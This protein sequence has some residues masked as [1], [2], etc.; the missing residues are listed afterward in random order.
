MGKK[1]KDSFQELRV[2]AGS[3]RWVCDDSI[4]GFKYTSE[5]EPLDSIVGQPR[6]IEAIKLGSQIDS[7]GYNIFVTG[8]SGTGRMTAVKRLLEKIADQCPITYDYAYVNNFKEHDK[9]NLI[10]LPRSRGKDFKKA[11]RESLDLIQQR[12]PKIFEDEEYQKRRSEIVEKF[13]QKE[14][15]II[16]EFDKRIEK[17][18]FVRG[19]LESENGQVTPEVF[20]VINEKPTRIEDLDDLVED[21]V[22]SQEKANELKKKYKGFHQEV[23]RLS[24]EGMH[25]MK[26]YR[27]EM[28]T[29]DRET[30]RMFVTSVYEE[31]A[32][33]F[34]TEKIKCFIKELIDYTLDNLAELS[35]ALDPNNKEQEKHL[36]K[37][38]VN[39]ILDNTDTELP[40][41]II[42]RYPNYSNLFGSFER[43]YDEKGNWRTDFTEIRAGSILRADKGFLI[44]NA[45]DMFSE[46]GVW[47]NLKR[48]L[49]YGKLDIQAQSNNGIAAYLKPEPID[50]DVKVIIIGGGSLYRF[51]YDNEKGFKKIFKVN[52]QFDY[53]TART[54]ELLKDYG[55]FVSAIC[56][57]EALP[58]ADASG[59]AAIA[60]WACEHAGD[61]TRM[62]LKFSDVADV[63]REAA[64]YHRK[65]GKGHHINRQD[66][67]KACEM[68]EMRSDLIDEKLKYQILAGNTLIDTHGHVIGQINGL[69]ILS[70]GLVSFGKP[71]RI[72]A[73]VSAGS[74]GIVN[75]ER[76]AQMSGRIHTKGLMTITAFLQ[77]LFAQEY[78]MSMEGSIAFEQNYGGIDGDSASIA[79]IY[80][81]LS[82]LSLV[83]INQ[84]IAVTG[85]VNQLGNVQP[86]GGVNEKIIGFYDIC[87][88]R[89]LTGNQGVIIPKQNVKNL[90]LK[91]SIIKDIEEGNFHIWQVEHISEACEILLGIPWG[92]TSMD[93]KGHITYSEGSLLD[94]ANSKLDL[95][96]EKAKEFNTIVQPVRLVDQDGNQSQIASGEKQKVYG[97]SY[98]IEES[99]RRDGLHLREE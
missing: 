8:I 27:R 58:H 6:A 17:E 48:V 35:K 21:N 71:S 80:V 60:E 32:E 97:D 76:E 88:E 55:K 99:I 64:Y 41:V 18:E 70:T 11:M 19:T 42:E 67:E 4:F 40:P 7:K 1:A 23:L 24:Q 69:S 9:P 43:S 59:V 49:L 86:I 37:Y 3:T 65:K 85:S 54:E 31:V 78:P 50:V 81:L 22:I 74:R 79:E 68:R 44:V 96:R 34:P 72:T 56:E 61:Q 20:P 92:K 28:S 39:V 26:N 46:S 95:Y 83:P 77:D 38:E 2:E 45:Q 53:E 36:Q 84:E 30:A 13:K 93:S 87:K 57:K 14:S 89:G 47:T 75:I 73:V 63:I 91:K 25:L 15:E 90:M 12:L 16:G 10:Q 5:V 51:L 52:A 66:V 29:H 94:I 82:A 62:T 98:M 33:E